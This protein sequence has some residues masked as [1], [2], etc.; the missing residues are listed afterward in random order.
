M[1]KEL[2]KAFGQIS[3]AME[4]HQKDLQDLLQ[5]KA[6]YENILSQL[7]KKQQTPIVVKQVATIQQD[8]Q[9]AKKLINKCQTAL[10]F[11]SESL[12]FPNPN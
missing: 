10:K 11:F 12:S 6:N 9:Y 3:Q 5:I 2:I 7:A 4:T 1:D 8:L